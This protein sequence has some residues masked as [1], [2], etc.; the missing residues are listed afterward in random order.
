MGDRLCCFLH[1]KSEDV[2]RLLTDCCPQCNRPFGF[3]LTDRPATIGRYTV[4]DS[5]GRGFFGATYKAVH[6]PFENPVA[7]KVIPKEIYI[8]FGKTFSRECEDHRQ[9]AA[10]SEHLTKIE[11]YF[12]R[13]V[14]FG[15]IRIPCHVAVLQWIRGD[16]LSKVLSQPEAIDATQ[17]A[18][19]A[20]DLLT[21]LLELRKGGKRHN[22]LHNKNIVI[23]VNEDAP[24]RLDRV[25]SDTIAVAVDFGSIGDASSSGGGRIGDIRYAGMHIRDL[26]QR[27]LR[28]PGQES[29]LN[30][31]LAFA[32]EQTTRIL[33]RE[34]TSQRLD[35]TDLKSEVFNLAIHR[36][37]TPVWRSALELKSFSEHYNAQTIES[38]Y[39]PNLLVL[40]PHVSWIDSIKAPG[41]QV[42]SGMRGCGKTMILK[43]LDFHA[44]AFR[45]EG[46][47]AAE[48]I[49]KVKKD[50]F[51]GLFL[52]CAKLLDP[53]SNTTSLHVKL[54][55]AY[56]HAILKAV[57][58]LR[59]LQADLVDPRFAQA[60]TNAIEQSLAKTKL[61]RLRTEYELEEF[62]VQTQLRLGHED[63][64]S[65]SANPAAVFPEFSRLLGKIAP[66]IFGGAH[67]L[68]LLDDVS[69]RFI[70][71]NAISELISALLFSNEKCSFKFTT[72]EQTLELVLKSPGKIEH[73]RQGRDYTV[74]NLGAEVSR[75]I[76][77]TPADGRQFI[78]DIL[79]RRRHY[80]FRHP[81]VDATTILGD[82]RLSDIAMAIGRAFERSDE[83]KRV[84]W[85][86]TAI[87]NLCVGDIGEV[88]RLYEDV[89]KQA[90]PDV[91]PVA[92]EVQHKCF[93]HICTSALHDINRR[94][95]KYKNHALGFANAAHKLLRQSVETRDK[96]RRVRQYAQVYVSISTGDQEWTYRAIRDLID[97]GIYVLDASTAAPRTKRVDSD[98]LQQFILTYRKLYGLSTLIGLSYRDR[99]ELSGD[100]LEKWLR[101]PDQAAEILMRNV[102]KD[103]EGIDEVDEEAPLS[104]GP[105]TAIATHKGQ[106]T[107]MTLIYGETVTPPAT[108][109]PLDPETVASALNAEIRKLEVADIPQL[110]LLIG[111]F[112]F[113][114]RCLGSFERLLTPGRFGRA[115]LIR[116]PE[117]PRREKISR[118][119]TQNDIPIEE[120]PAAN[121][122]KWKG[123]KSQSA[124]VDVS[125]LPKPAIFHFCR[126]ILKSTGKLYLCHTQASEYY[127]REEEIEPV[128]RAHEKEDVAALLEGVSKLFKGEDEPYRCEKLTKEQSDEQRPRALI[129]FSSP[130]H[131]RLQALLDNRYYDY[132]AIGYPTNEN[133][134][135]KISKLAAR[136]ASRNINGAVSQPVSS[137]SLEENINFQSTLYFD[138]YYRSGYNIEIG[139]TGSKISAVAAS[140]LASRWK[141]AQVWY[142]K[143]TQFSVDRFTSGVGPTT[144]Y[145]VTLNK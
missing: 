42:I 80:Y 1:P 144:I 100:E 140:I 124:L 94:D 26:T 93:Q 110:D 122:F 38:A 78:A 114:E 33:L 19:I 27:I 44:R 79:N 133:N 141:L 129:A 101:H 2:D 139:L 13:D 120:L 135:A 123:R 23:S 109:P 49:A 119:F 103:D 17:T 72:E 25:R 36:S 88:I 18:Q 86:I 37:L 60:I 106:Q 6:G 21:L 68:F 67:V 9:L 20:L 69:T 45:N 104:I 131:E 70:S 126:Q 73:A 127:P 71:E 115:Y 130:K 138:L 29:D 84:Y 82:Q 11:D 145:Q 12:D 54:L 89:L 65:L 125:G 55:I 74:F 77:K 112:G 75:L 117:N 35:F 92:A 96:S 116:F 63:F 136:F 108:P 34:P 46:E 95:P 90:K 102:A 61:P 81:N 85:G 121:V 53:E 128:L 143:P 28:N 105:E 107:E 98:P 16:T 10:N 64:L 99:F 87:T 3:P 14:T 62:L 47:A 111:S 134:R 40:P 142:V 50:R 7:I 22:D 43:S 32:L 56:A 113:E 118:V 30:W 83:R 57:Q 39:V 66:D 24:D 41:P 58:N 137:L 51:V 15:E 76:R 91:Y 48:V 5:L 31:R 4:V 97:A 52:A 132:V 8:L 59:D